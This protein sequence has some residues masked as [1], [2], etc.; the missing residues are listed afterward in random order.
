MY[1]MNNR[2]CIPANLSQFKK[3]EIVNWPPFK[4]NLNYLTKMNTIFFSEIP[5]CFVKGFVTNK[6][7]A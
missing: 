6:D 7:F 1:Y 2:E 5:S 4:L 3:S